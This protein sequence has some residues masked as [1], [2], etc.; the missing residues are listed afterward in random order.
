MSGIET[1]N[2]PLRWCARG[3]DLYLCCC[4]FEFRFC[5]IALCFRDL[6]C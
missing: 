3:A 6:K 1:V 2:I 5:W 4:Q